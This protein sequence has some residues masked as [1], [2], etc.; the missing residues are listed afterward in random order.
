MIVVFDT[1][2]LGGNKMTYLRMILLAGSAMIVAAGCSSLE[3]VYIPE[4]TVIDTPATVKVTID[5]NITLS[6]QEPKEV[7]LPISQIGALDVHDSE[8]VV[9]VQLDPIVQ[10]ARA[11]ARGIE[12]GSRQGRT[13]LGADGFLVDSAGVADFSVECRK[14]RK[15]DKTDCQGAT[16]RRRDDI[17]E[18]ILLEP[19]DLGGTT[20]MSNSHVAKAE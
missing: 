12:I 13:E 3:P 8:L 20:L 9:V 14:K 11:H 15:A 18:M 19:I 10:V 1:T 4:G 6:A 2:A 5:K 16:L 17:L 7:R